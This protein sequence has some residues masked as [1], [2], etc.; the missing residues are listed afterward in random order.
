MET[1][2]SSPLARR[3]PIVAVE[4]RSWGRARETEGGRGERV[5]S[6]KP[7]CIVLEGA[8]ASRAGR[9]LENAK[10]RAG[11]AA[12]RARERRKNLR[13]TIQLPTQK[14]ITPGKQGSFKLRSS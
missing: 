14:F 13:N 7:M 2:R 10:E 11:A 8:L 6:S 5:A 12:T 9:L 1:G 4:H 3:S